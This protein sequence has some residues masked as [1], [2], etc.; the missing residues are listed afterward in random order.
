MKL[1]TSLIISFIALQHYLFLILE[2][3]VWATP[4]GLKIFKHDQKT[5]D[6]SAILAKNQGLYN[7]FLA[8]GLVWSLLLK[9]APQA[10]A[11]QIFFLTCILIAGIYGGVT[12]AKNILL[13]QALPACIALILLLTQFS[14]NL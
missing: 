4:L 13:I 7:G 12:A 3:F 9:N 6:A 2:M 11:L 5:A 10:Q 1:L 14:F 8:S